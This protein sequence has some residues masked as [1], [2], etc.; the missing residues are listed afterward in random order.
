MTSIS[1]AGLRK[2]FIGPAK[3]H[4]LGSLVL[5]LITLWCYGNTLTWM[6][7]RFVGADSYYS[8][9]FLIPAIFA[10]LVWRKRNE[11]SEKDFSSSWW[12]LGLIIFS[13]F[14][15]IVGTIVYVFSISG[16]SLFILLIGF[17]L[18]I[19]GRDMTRVIAFPLAFLL[20]MFPMPEAFLTYV[21]FPM[22][23]LVAKS[24]ASIA[25]MIGIPAYREGFH[26]LI[27]AGDLLVGNPCSGL[28][29]LIAFLALGA[30]T[31]NL[32]GISTLR[33]GILIFLAIPIALL[34]NMLR[35][36]LL[37]ILAQHFGLSA[38]DPDT[39]LHMATGLFVFAVALPLLFLTGKLMQWKR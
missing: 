19:L 14:L 18:F 1:N 38:V 11:L 20:F 27:P 6:Y 24:G 33:Q 10:Y 2:S 30:L 22:K 15:H 34:S 21:S 28:R 23:M 3:V 13:L 26:I 5:A 31:A 7:G 39:F 36:P 17:S 29:S 37:I 4:I 25:E 35:V 9:G 12:G 32:A 8:H 16:F